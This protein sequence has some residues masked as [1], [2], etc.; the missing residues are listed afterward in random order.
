MSDLISVIV[1]QLS[2][3]VFKAVNHGCRLDL[4]DLAVLADEWLK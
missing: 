4:Q 1:S 2:I 3:A